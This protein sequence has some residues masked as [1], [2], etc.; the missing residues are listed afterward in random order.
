[1]RAILVARDIR[2][3][4]LLPELQLY[5]RVLADDHGLTVIARSR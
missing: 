2:P 3:H 5:G 4:T 1:V